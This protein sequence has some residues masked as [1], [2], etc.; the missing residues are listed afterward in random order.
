MQ[1]ISEVWRAPLE[2][3]QRKGQHEDPRAQALLETVRQA[4][5]NTGTELRDTPHTSSQ[6][7]DVESEPTQTPCQHELNGHLGHPEVVSK[8]EFFPPG[9]HP[10]RPLKIPHR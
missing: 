10:I 3:V 7:G 6:A 9:A 8:E 4:L 5:G 2:D 1:A